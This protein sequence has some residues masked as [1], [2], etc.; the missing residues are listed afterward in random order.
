MQSNAISKFS[1]DKGSYNYNLNTTYT[2]K[3]AI[4]DVN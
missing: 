3:M 2:S 1:E 4:V